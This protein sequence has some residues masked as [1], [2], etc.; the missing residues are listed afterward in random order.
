M[1]ENPT[2]FSDLLGKIFYASAFADKVIKREEIER[3]N[4]LLITEWQ[5]ERILLSFFE[6]INLN[7]DSKKL[8]DELVAHKIQYPELFEEAIASKIINTSY[9]IMNA[10]SGTNKSEIV[11]I[12]QLTNVLKPKNH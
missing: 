1:K 6:C 11:F 9:R 4:E 8:I 5:D 12:S 10:S 3:L 2:H 7:Y